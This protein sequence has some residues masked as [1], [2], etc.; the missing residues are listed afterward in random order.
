MATQLN[1]K[2]SGTKWASIIRAEIKQKIDELI[3]NNIRKPCI[4][5]IIVGNRPDSSTYVAH[6][7]IA[8]KEVGIEVIILR[9]ETNIT[10]EELINNINLFNS[11]ENIDGILVQLP[12]PSHITERTILETILPQKDVD[13]IGSTH[14]GNLA[15]RGCTPDFI[16]CTAKGCIELLKREGIQIEGKNAVV[17]GRSNIVGIPVALLL[18]KENATVTMCHSKTKDLNLHLQ[19]ADIVIV[20]IGQPNFV[21]MDWIK[22]GAV[23]IDVGINRIN[24]ESKKSGFRLVGDVEESCIDICGKI[25][26]VPGGVGPMTIAMLLQNTLEVHLRT[27]KI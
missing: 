19:N 11:N 17:V 23:I 6:K 25:T 13:A 15:L 26:P 4:A 10:Q 16:P 5:C 21:K 9:L 2:I 12:L 1:K 14:M 20:A 8:A 3:A 22:E 27:H 7:E 18:Q 24:D